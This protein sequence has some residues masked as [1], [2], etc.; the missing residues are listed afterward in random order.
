MLVHIIP[1][2]NL[3]GIEKDLLYILKEEAGNY[4]HKVLVFNTEGPMT[5]RWED[6]GA[7]VIHLNILHVK[8]HR[9]IS[10]LKLEVGSP[11]GIMCWSPTKIGLVSFA[12]KEFRG[13]IMMHLG[14]PVKWSKKSTNFN[15]ILFAIAKPKFNLKLFCCS[16][17]VLQTVRENSFLNQFP[18]EVSYNPVKQLSRNPFVP[19]NRK[20]VLGMIARMDEIKDFDTV[21]KAMKFLPENVRLELGGDGFD[22][23]RL[24]TLADKNASE[25]I[26]FKGFVEDVYEWFLELTCF[27]YGTTMFEGLGNVVTEAMANGIPCVLPDLPMMRE[28][29]GDYAM[30]YQHGNEQD[31]AN[32]VQMV[33]ADKELQKNMSEGAFYRVR[34]IFNQQNYYKTRV[35]FLESKV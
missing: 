19:E 33:L 9:F 26:V 25:R 27:V 8:P 30:Y 24:E 4:A 6:L 3:G 12:L 5:K 29:G 21:I 20:N 32:K 35:G 34:T 1:K 14:N 11:V 15:R 22:R 2:A 16:K 23:S 10:L 18:A 17:H 28:I 13:N 7:E 31:C